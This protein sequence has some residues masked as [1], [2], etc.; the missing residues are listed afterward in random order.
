MEQLVLHTP[1]QEDDIT[2]QICNAFDYVPTKES[3]IC[4]TIYLPTIPEDY[5]IG[6]IVGSSG[7]GKSTILRELFGCANKSFAWDNTKGIASNFNSFEEASERFG[8]VGLNSIPTWLK[9]YS[10]LSNGEKFRADLASV[11]ED[12]A[13][14]DEFTSVVNREVAISCCMSLKKYI[15]KKGLKRITFASCHDDI[16]PYLQP[17]WIWN[18]DAHEFYNGRYLH[19]PQINIEIRSC[20][21]SAWDMFK[22]HHY[23]SSEINKS[24]QCYLATYQDSPVGFVA[25]IS[26]PNGN[27]KH[28]FRE[29]RLVILPDYQGMG[30]GN[31]LSE[32]IADA[33]HKAGCRYFSKTANPRCGEHRDNSPLWR[34]TTHNHKQRLDYKHIY[35]TLI[36]NTWANNAKK[37]ENRLCYAHEYV[38]DG[39]QYEY[40]YKCPS[41]QQLSL[42]EGD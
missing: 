34:P 30:I 40:A 2:R 28:G 27:W 1:I 10:V 18:T 37:H 9:P 41:S 42:F 7:S 39:L 31:L 15:Q 14:I 38:G 35:T 8:A 20:S 16:I 26:F 33:Y 21:V 3:G 11:L 17:D 12:N 22:Q 23:L 19:R 6:L 4:T 24:C 5:Q 29:S 13:V 36:A 32:T 25:V